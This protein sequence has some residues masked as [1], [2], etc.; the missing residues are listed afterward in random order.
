MTGRGTIDRMGR[1]SRWRPVRD[2]RR[3]V[4]RRFGRQLASRPSRRT[5][6]GGGGSI[7]RRAVAASRC[8]GAGRKGELG[9]AG[10]RGRQSQGPAAGDRT[11]RK[12]QWTL[13]ARRRSLERWASRR[14]PLASALPAASVAQHDHDAVDEQRPADEDDETGPDREHGAGAAQLQRGMRSGHPARMSRSTT[15]CLHHFACAVLRLR[16]AMA[17]VDLCADLGLG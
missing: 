4:R 6:G 9:A 11:S 3:R 10:R 13:A 8:A 7:S 12:G 17:D 15:R 5:H 2:C 1:R 16:L 14:S